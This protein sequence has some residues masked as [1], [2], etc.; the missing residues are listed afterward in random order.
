MKTP[1]RS[2]YICPGAST[3]ILNTSQIHPG[4]P[5]HHIT[6]HIQIHVQNDKRQKWQ[7]LEVSVWVAMVSIRVSDL[8]IWAPIIYQDGL[9]NGAF[10]CPSCGCTA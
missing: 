4:T 2:R 10:A 8:T 6:T 3:T 1:K 7:K 9:Y 5:R